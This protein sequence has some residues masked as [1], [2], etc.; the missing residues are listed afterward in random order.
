MLVFRGKRALEQETIDAR[1]RG[2]SCERRRD[3]A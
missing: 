1:E 2:S 3:Q